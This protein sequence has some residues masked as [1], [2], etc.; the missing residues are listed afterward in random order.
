MN[1]VGSFNTK[2]QFGDYD[3]TQYDVSLRMCLNASDNPR[4]T[5]PQPANA[6][7]GVE[8]INHDSDSRDSTGNCGGRSNVGSVMLPAIKLTNAA[9]SEGVIG[10]RAA[11]IT[12]RTD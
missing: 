11:S 10:F 1:W 2:Q 3:G 9:Q 8:E 4:L 5:L 12:T 6:G 7:V